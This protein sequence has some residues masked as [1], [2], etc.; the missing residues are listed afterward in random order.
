VGVRKGVGPI[1]EIMKLHRAGSF[2]VKCKLLPC[3]SLDLSRR[4]RTVGNLI[5]A[6]R[7][8]SRGASRLPRNFEKIL[9]GRSAAKFPSRNPV[10]PVGS[11]FKT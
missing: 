4:P 6:L 9:Q 1:C 5:L 2:T 3:Q 10:Q 8:V 7:I 11:Y